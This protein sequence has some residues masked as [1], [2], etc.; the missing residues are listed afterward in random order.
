MIWIYDMDLWYGSVSSED[1]VNDVIAMLYIL[2]ESLIIK[3]V[4]DY[5]FSYYSD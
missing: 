5:N 4:S 2:Q 1:D 3:L